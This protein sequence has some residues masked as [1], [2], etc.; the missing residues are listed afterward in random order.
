MVDQ[1]G[2]LTEVLLRMSIFKDLGLTVFFSY[3]VFGG[4]K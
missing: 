3:I 4:K 1:Q 2:V